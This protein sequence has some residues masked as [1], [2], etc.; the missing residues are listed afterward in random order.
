MT[1]ESRKAGQ[2]LSLE[3]SSS[4]SALW[5]LWGVPEMFGFLLGLYGHASFMKIR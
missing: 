2:W 5:R 3:G 4:Y 1:P